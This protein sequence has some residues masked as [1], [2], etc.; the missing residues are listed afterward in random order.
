VKHP[1]RAIRREIRT[2]RPKRPGLGARQLAANEGP[3]SIRVSDLMTPAPVTIAWDGTV[4]AA[5]KLMRGRRIRH[6]PVLDDK[7]QLAGIVTDRDLRHA[8]FHPAVRDEPGTAPEA[9]GTVPVSDVMTWGVVSVRPDTELR[10]AARVMAE[11]R[12]GAVPVVEHGRVVGILTETDVIKAFARIL[13][14]SVL[15]IPMRWGLEA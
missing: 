9:V 12:I 1:K 2:R 7:G 14:E 3:E 10:Q 4:G 11:R 8:V 6:L 5:W 13:G 15:S